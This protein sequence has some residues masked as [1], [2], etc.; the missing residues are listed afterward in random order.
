MVPREFTSLA[1]ERRYLEKLRRKIQS[2]LSQSY[3]RSLLCSQSPGLCPT[4]KIFSIMKPLPG[5]VTSQESLKKM[6]NIIKKETGYVNLLVTNAGIAG[7]GLKG[8]SPR[9]TVSDFVK[10]A[11]SSPMPDFKAV[12]AFNCTAVYCTILAF[13]ELLDEGNK[14]RNYTKSQV[15]ATA[16]INSFMRDPRTGFAYC[17]SKVALVSMIKCF[18]TY[19][20]PWGIRFNAIAAGCTYL[21]Y[22]ICNPYSL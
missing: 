21:P 3:T 22:Y 1:G 5:D 11:W 13:L 19:C 10:Y 15:I 14:K 4:N 12:C 9:A 8:L 18:S 6:A 20:V 7:P 16:S 2:T 17:S